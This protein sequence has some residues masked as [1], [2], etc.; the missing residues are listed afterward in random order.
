M[1]ADGKFQVR[2]PD[3]GR[4]FVLVVSSNAYRNAGQDPSRGDIAQLGRYVQPPM[5]LLGQSKY[6]WRERT[7]RSDD[8][9]NVVF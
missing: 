2:L 8:S 9:L 5:D 4:Y 6:E 7:I 1:D 3:T